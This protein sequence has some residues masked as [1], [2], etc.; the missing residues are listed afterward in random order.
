MHFTVLFFLAFCLSSTGF[1]VKLNQSVLGLIQD[2]PNIGSRLIN[3]LANWKAQSC[4]LPF[5][6]PRPVIT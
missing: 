6:L 2:K 5:T 4:L 3:H 1:W